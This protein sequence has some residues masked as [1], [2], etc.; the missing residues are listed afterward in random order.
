MVMPS[1]QSKLACA[2]HVAD[3]TRAGLQRGVSL[4]VVIVIVML[5]SLLALW[6]MRSALFA[7]LVTGNEADYQ[8]AYQA[9]QAMVQDAK[10]DIAIN[11]QGQGKRGLQSLLQFPEDQVSFV[12]WAFE[13]EAQASKCK[14][15]IC[16]R[17]ITAENFWDDP[18]NFASMVS[19]GAR[20]SQFSG[21]TVG[22]DINPILKATA[23]NKGA[24][25]WVEPMQFQSSQLGS[26]NKTLS[27]GSSQPVQTD[28][29]FRIT[30]IALGL[31]GASSNDT[32]I[33]QR[34]STMAVIQT[35]VAMPHMTG[36]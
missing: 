16:L 2:H 4:I 21:A 20:F 12:D 22:A 33:A 34:S 14:D 17:R 31:K 7:E 3:A 19:T 36:E 25:Y 28:L 11:T 30:A 9:A 32:D 6:A 29:L 5:M 35:I 18:T 24:W 8:R 13:L 27:G 1:S 23:T 15:G 10:D 26:T